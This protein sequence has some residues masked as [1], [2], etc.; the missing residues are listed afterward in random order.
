MKSKKA[1]HNGHNTKIWMLEDKRVKY[2]DDDWRGN[3]QGLLCP[4][5]LEGRPMCWVDFLLSIQFW[6]FIKF[7]IIEDCDFGTRFSYCLKIKIKNLKLYSG[8]FKETVK[9]EEIIQHFKRCTTLTHFQWNPL[10]EWQI[11]NMKDPR[12]HFIRVSVFGW[13]NPKVSV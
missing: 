5:Q 12:R 9:Q 8:V 10:C 11:I 3:V 6:S 7:Q 4:T 13:R 2:E 1:S